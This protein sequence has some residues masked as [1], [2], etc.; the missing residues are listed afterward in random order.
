[1]S[2]PREFST[3]MDGS[4]CRECNMY[5]KEIKTL[6]AK[7]N[8]AIEALEFYASGGHNPAGI[9]VEAGGRAAKTLKELKDGE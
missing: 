2:K 3:F 7:L 9:A 5:E 1:M 8:K 4:D 6:Q